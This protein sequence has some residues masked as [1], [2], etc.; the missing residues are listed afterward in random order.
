MAIL[1]VLVQKLEKINLV[2]ISSSLNKLL[3]EC[4][5]SLKKKKNNTVL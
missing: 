4:I 2:A 3:R 1:E 5:L